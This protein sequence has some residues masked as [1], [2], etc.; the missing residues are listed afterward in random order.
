[1]NLT[2]VNQLFWMTY[3]G[4]VRSFAN[5][6]PD[7]EEYEQIP[8]GTMI[9]VYNDKNPVFPGF[10]PIISLTRKDIPVTGIEIIIEED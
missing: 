1:M 3:P 8:D 7:E 10:Y 9:V 5:A 6:L 4:T 2:N